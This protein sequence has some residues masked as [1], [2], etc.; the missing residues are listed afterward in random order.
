MSDDRTATHPAAPV[1]FE[2]WCEHPGCKKWGGLGF[3]KGNQTMR[4]WCGE[5]YPHWDRKPDAAQNS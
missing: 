3:G 4:W 5:H 1:H 2:H